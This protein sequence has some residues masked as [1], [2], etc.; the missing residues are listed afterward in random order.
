MQGLVRTAY[1]LSCGLIWGCASTPS[2]PPPEVVEVPK[3]EF[4]KIP[5]GLLIPCPV[6]DAAPPKTN[7][8][9]LEQW[10]QRREAMEECARRLDAIRKL[11]E[12]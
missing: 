7:G 1:L 10:R 5:Q 12:Q 2:C 9:L 4:Q 3:V 6:P 8:E 11:Q